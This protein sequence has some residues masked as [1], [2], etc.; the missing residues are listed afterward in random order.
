MEKV[1]FLDRDGVINDNTNHVNK[2]ED[3]I[4]Y[5]KSKKALKKAYDNG[6]KIFVVTNQG[7]IEL[8]HINHKDINEIHNKM[9][10]DLY[11]YCEIEDIEYCPDFNR[12]S[13]FRKPEPGMILKLAEK[14]NINLEK[15]WMI[16]DRDTDIEAG[17]KAKCKT[18]KI[19]KKSNESD[20]NGNDLLEIIDKIIQYDKSV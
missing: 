15:S 5:D 11:D 13:K 19:G 17:K 4:I 7:G 16:G 20:V 2:P 8:G 18:A 6:Y 14:H 10:E 12:T 3:L 1:L 9:I